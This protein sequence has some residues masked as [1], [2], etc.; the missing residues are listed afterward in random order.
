MALSIKEKAGLVKKYRRASKDTG[1]SDVQIAIL[2][3]NIKSLTEHMKTHKKD[4]HSR[5]GL[6]SMVGRRRKLLDY[7]KQTA[8]ERYTNLIKQ[9]GI[10][11]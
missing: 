9:L 8:T 4:F 6:V 3:A 2:S 1:S 5:R 10:R 7:L 11:K